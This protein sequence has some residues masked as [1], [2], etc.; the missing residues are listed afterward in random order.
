MHEAKFCAMAEGIPHH[1]EWKCAVRGG[2]VSVACKGTKANCAFSCID[3]LAM[4]CIMDFLAIAAS[5]IYTAGGGMLAFLH[6]DPKKAP[7]TTT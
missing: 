6:Y 5:C 7:P 2:T 4:P 3:C 1:Q